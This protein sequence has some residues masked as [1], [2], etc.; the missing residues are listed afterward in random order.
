MHI[1]WSNLESLF[2]PVRMRTYI[3]DQIRYLG[4]VIHYPDF[5]SVILRHSEC[6][7]E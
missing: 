1:V 3:S 7:C 6:N 4:K 2:F 5:Y